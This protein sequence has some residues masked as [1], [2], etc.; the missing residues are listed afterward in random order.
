M[1]DD[2]LT[3]NAIYPGVRQ[4][5]D[6]GYTLSWGAGAGRLTLTIPPQD[7][8]LIQGTGDVRLTDGNSDVF[9]RDCT[10]VDMF[11]PYGD[12]GPIILVLE[13]GRWRW[14]FGAVSGRWNQLVDRTQTVPVMDAP[15][16]PHG[17]QPLQPPP[18]PPG[19][20]PIIPWTRKTARE[21][22]KILLAAMRVT[23]YDIDALDEFATPPVH[24]DYVNPA[25]ALQQLCADLGCVVAYH[26]HT[27]NVLISKHGDGAPLPDGGILNDSQELKAR[28]RPSRI[29]LR[30]HREWV[31]MRVALVPAAEDFDGTIRTL[32]TVSWR[33]LGNDWS[34]VMPP[35]FVNLP[36]DKFLPGK[37]TT[38]DAV[39]L[40]R[41]SLWR[42]YIPVFT[43]DPTD[44]T[45][46]NAKNAALESL[47]NL[48]AP[49]KTKTKTKNQFGIITV[50]KKIS[51]A[52]REA[53]R[54]AG[55]DGSTVGYMRLT[56]F[57]C[58]VVT[59]DLLRPAQSPARVM[60]KH[61][62]PEQMTLGKNILQVYDQTT[63]TTE[64]KT[65]FRVVDIGDD[66][67]AV[68]FEGYVWALNSDGRLVMPQLVIECACEFQD[69]NRQY[70]RTPFDYTLANGPAG[71]PERAVATIVRDEVRFQRVAVYGDKDEGAN[72]FTK[73]TDNMKSIKGR[74]K[75]LQ[76]GEARKYELEAA[77]EIS[78]AG[79]RAILP[80]GA[81]QQVTWSISPPTTRASRNT[82]H[83]SYLPSYESRRT[84]EENSLET[85]RRAKFALN[86][87][88]A[89]PD[90]IRA[91]R[92]PAL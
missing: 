6:A 47:K 24:W 33:P 38:T 51:W 92:N 67:Q 20:E 43:A 53:N 79:L 30:G 69:V 88:L 22:A 57:R 25:V 74:V 2:T 9:V 86:A 17:N 59:D 60:G 54:L 23:K 44:P 65:P 3:G 35:H 8:S 73:W 31:Q 89:L 27:G 62:P 34:A 56:N 39:A 14:D 29:R 71:K 11:A 75:Y 90:I 68:V 55:L 10:V 64:V 12:A 76:Q 61:N 5:I 18:V 7:L 78:Y 70:Y 16:D 66:Q 82:E 13:D 15:L 63:P 84:R 28:P 83:S 72:I 50:N 49:P 40:A 48:I 26:P 32:D 21:L 87:A 1:A 4:V 46:P 85:Q 41:K 77:E 52:Q 45:N 37:R 81:I 19:E 42:Y 36:A 80:D 91:V 58:E